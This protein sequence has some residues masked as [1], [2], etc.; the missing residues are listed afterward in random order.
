MHEAF[1]HG[2]RGSGGFFFQPDQLAFTVPAEVDDGMQQKAN[3]VAAF[4]QQPQHR[5]DKERHV[6]IGELDN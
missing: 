3:V 5:I 6:V 2:M 1:A 4:V